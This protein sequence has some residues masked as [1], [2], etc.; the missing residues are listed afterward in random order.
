MYLDYCRAAFSVQVSFSVL[1]KKTDPDTLVKDEFRPPV[2]KMHPSFSP[3]ATE[4]DCRDR[5]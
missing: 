3:I 2:I 5:F 4:Y 1:N